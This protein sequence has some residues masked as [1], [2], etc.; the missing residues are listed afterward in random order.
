MGKDISQIASLVGACTG[1][2]WASQV[3]PVLAQSGQLG[4]HMDL[5][6]SHTGKPRLPARAHTNPAWGPYGICTTILSGVLWAKA[7]Q[8]PSG[9]RLGCLARTNPMVSMVARSNLGCICSK[10]MPCFRWRPRSVWLWTL[11]KESGVCYWRITTVTGEYVLVYGKD[12]RKVFLANP[13]STLK[14]KDKSVWAEHFRQISSLNYNI[15]RLKP[16][17]K[18]NDCSPILPCMEKMKKILHYLTTSIT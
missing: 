17:Y 3:C 12:T 2:E 1:F 4:L 10:N 9:K 18:W 7:I 16:S 15:R 6:G 13:V 5:S 14:L 11:L 8:G